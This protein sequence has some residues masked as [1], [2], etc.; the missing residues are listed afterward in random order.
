M[1]PCFD[2]EQNF[3]VGGGY[4][5][6]APGARKAGIFFIDGLGKLW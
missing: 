6:I 3:N 4:S 1:Q 2:Q 5:L